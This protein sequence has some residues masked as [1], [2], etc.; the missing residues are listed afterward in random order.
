MRDL[1]YIVTGQK[2]EQKQDCDFEHIV[3]GTNNYLRLM[4]WFDTAWNGTTK[5]IEV[6]NI[7]GTKIIE[8]LV[9]G[10]F[11]LP[12]QVT[13]DSIIKVKLYGMNK[14]GDQIVTDTMIINQS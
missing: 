9:N 3:R 4:F 1:K 14:K 7:S 2:I 6:S 5:A 12:S 10:S 13:G 11:V 8:P